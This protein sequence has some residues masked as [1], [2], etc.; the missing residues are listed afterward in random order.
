MEQNQILQKQFDQVN[1]ILQR[2]ED[3]LSSSKN[4]P[5][6]DISM[7][8]ETATVSGLTELSTP[9]SNVAMPKKK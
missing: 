3:A 1:E 5:I 7:H 6:Q 4:Q 8:T 9:R 2:M